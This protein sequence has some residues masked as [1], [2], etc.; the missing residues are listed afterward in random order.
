[1]TS[2]NETTVSVALTLKGDQHQQQL[3]AKGRQAGEEAELAGDSTTILSQTATTVVSESS[4]A[5]L[6]L[7]AAPVS[8]GFP[9]PP[10]ARPSC[11]LCRHDCGDQAGLRDHLLQQH[12]VAP[13][14]VPRL[15]RMVDMPSAAMTAAPS[16][17]GSADAS[18]ANDAAAAEPLPLTAFP[19]QPD[20]RQQTVGSMKLSLPPATTSESVQNLA[21]PPPS[22]ALHSCKENGKESQHGGKGG[23]DSD[24]FSALSTPHELNANEVYANNTNANLPLSREDK[25]VTPPASAVSGNH[26]NNN[27][28]NNDNKSSNGEGPPQNGL[29]SPNPPTDSAQQSPIG[30]DVPPPSSSSPNLVPSLPPA[31]APPPLTSAS[32]SS[33]AL[34]AAVSSRMGAQQQQHRPWP[35][36]LAMGQSQTFQSKTAAGE[37]EPGVLSNSGKNFLPREINLELLQAKHERLLTEEG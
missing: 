12:R 33:A 30:T 35:A 8:S 28:S 36:S 14:G 24:E 1:M 26:N 20:S 29:S 13:D 19:P 23:V 2:Q 34:S 4:S 10:Y 11:P 6:S 17:A 3:L 27:G 9:A 15:L 21:K 31:G 25:T 7:R 16:S 18:E 22:S 37:R 32:P 5:P